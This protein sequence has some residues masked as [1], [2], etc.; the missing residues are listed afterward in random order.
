[1]HT[2]F[3]W[4]NLREGKHIRR[5]RRRREDNIKMY[6]GEVVLEPGLHRCGLG[7]GQV[8]GSCECGNGHS[9]STNCGGIPE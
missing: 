9:L 4:E 3:W 7:K 1:M 2:E 8:E 6:L 5:L